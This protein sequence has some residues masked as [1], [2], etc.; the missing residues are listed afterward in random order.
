MASLSNLNSRRH[1]TVASSVLHRKASGSKRWASS[2]SRI[3][4][5]IVDNSSCPR[6]ISTTYNISVALLRSEFKSRKYWNGDNDSGRVLIR[7]SPAPPHSMDV[8][9]GPFPRGPSP[10][11]D[12]DSPMLVVLTLPV[13]NIC[14]ADRLPTLVVR[15]CQ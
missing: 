13:T 6:R 2:H 8:G 12:A 3:P 9:G 11:A 7:L 10:A 4:A 1:V 15:S 14:C 5:I